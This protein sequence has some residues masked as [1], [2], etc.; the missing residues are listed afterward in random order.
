MLFGLLIQESGSQFE[1]MIE[2][3]DDLVVMLFWFDAF[4]PQVVF[5]GGNWIRA[6]GMIGG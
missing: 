3:G 1:V 4:T 5:H 2:G 6:E